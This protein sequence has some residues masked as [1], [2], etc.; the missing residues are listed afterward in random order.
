MLIA[1]T[2]RLQR[3]LNATPDSLSGV[4]ANELCIWRIRKA[5]AHHSILNEGSREGR[6]RF[7]CHICTRLTEV[8]HRQLSAYWSRSIFVSCFIKL[9]FVNRF[10]GTSRLSVL[11]FLFFLLCFFYFFLEIAGARS[12][13]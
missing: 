11:Y 9:N 8:V 3:A 5:V 13:A 1:V 6:I 10:S 7:G 12:R 2:S 4:R